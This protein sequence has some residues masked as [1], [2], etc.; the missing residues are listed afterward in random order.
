MAYNGQ[1]TSPLLDR[2]QSRAH[3][4][5]TPKVERSRVPPAEKDI[6]IAVALMLG[7]LHN[8]IELFD[9]G[10]YRWVGFGEISTKLGQ[11]LDSIIT[12]MVGN[13]PSGVLR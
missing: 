13:E 9:F 4:G 3:C 12:T 11:N 6:E 5:T 2:L 10:N 1:N 7:A 8:S